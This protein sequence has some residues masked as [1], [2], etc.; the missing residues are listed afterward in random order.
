MIL[1]TAISRE[2]PVKLRYRTCGFGTDSTC[3]VAEFT[4]VEWTLAAAGHLLRA[5]A[6]AGRRRTFAIL[7]IVR[8]RKLLVRMR[9]KFNTA[10]AT[11][12][13]LAF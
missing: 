11:F 8:V 3:P 2:V 9:R 7:E 10:R 5:P 13:V 12:R 4:G 6:H 1:A